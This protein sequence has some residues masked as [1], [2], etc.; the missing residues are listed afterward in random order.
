MY[1]MIVPKKGG[2]KPY[3][4]C[5]YPLI[6]GLNCALGATAMRPFVEE[7][8]AVADTLV[9]AHPNAGLPNELGGYDETPEQTAAILGEFAEAGLVNVVGGCCGTNPDF[10]RALS[11]ELVV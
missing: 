8:A 6:V 9:S 11:K 10:I 4:T 7:V 3:C 5:R 2:P 1:K